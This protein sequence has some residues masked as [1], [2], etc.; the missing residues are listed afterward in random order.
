MCIWSVRARI[1]FGILRSERTKNENENQ[2]NITSPVFLR[3]WHKLNYQVWFQVLRE[4]C[5]RNPE[6]P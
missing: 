5:C 6:C 2:L 4:G 3:N 1:S